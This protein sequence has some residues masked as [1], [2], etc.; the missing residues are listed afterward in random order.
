[1]A[2]A[3]ISPPSATRRVPRPSRTLR[4]AGTT[5]ACGDGLRRPIPK[6][7]LRPVLALR[8]CDACTSAPGPVIGSGGCKSGDTCLGRVSLPDNRDSSVP[9]VG[10]TMRFGWFWPFAQI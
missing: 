7:N 5:N 9:L 1:V 3:L 6:R 8:D 10:M 4:R 2:Q